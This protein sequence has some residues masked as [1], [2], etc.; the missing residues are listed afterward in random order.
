MDRIAEYLGLDPAEVRRRNLVQPDEFPYATGLLFRDGSPQSYDSGN[1]PELLRGVLERSDY[2]GWRERQAGAR[3]QGRLIGIG[4]ACYVE[5]CGLGPYEGAK[6]RLTNRGQVLVTMAAAPQGQGYETVY[7]QIAASAMGLDMEHIRVTTGDTGRIPFGQGTFASRITATAGPAVFQACRA[8]RDRIFHTASIM[9][10]VEA[11]EFVFR[12]NRICLPTDESVSVT[13]QQVTQVANVGKHGITLLRGVQ[14][15]LETS[16]YFAPEQAAYASGTHVAVVEVDPETG[17]TE[18]LRYVIG[19]DCGN[20]INPLLVDGQV[21]GGFAAGIGNAL[22]EEQIY[23]DSGQPLTTSYLDFSLP[24]S[25]EVPPVELV[26][27]HSPSP[28]NPLGVKGAG[29]GGTIP[30]PATIASAVE[31]ALR[32]LGARINQLPVT[33]ARVVGAINGTRPA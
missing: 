21:L 31:D 13:L 19:H 30:A 10:K 16:S 14:P 6:A 4:I 8:L 23:D 1:F 26:H 20:V 7:A 27:V 25:M 32:P 11:A 15:G 12:G 24:S 29:E 28:L 22:Y 18:I 2:L 3:A 9:L 33:P 5:G 17:R